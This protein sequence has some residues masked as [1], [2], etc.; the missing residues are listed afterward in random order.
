MGLKVESQ[1]IVLG[2]DFPCKAESFNKKC[3]GVLSIF[4]VLIR[5]RLRISYIHGTVALAIKFSSPDRD[6]TAF[7]RD[8]R[9]VRGVHRDN[10]PAEDVREISIW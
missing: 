1:H 2:C 3:G 4:L 6:R 5:R 10:I 7:G 9:A 8:R